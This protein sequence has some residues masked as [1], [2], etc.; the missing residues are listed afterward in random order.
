M[1][2]HAQRKD[3]RETFIAL[4]NKL[5]TLEEAKTENKTNI[6]SH[7]KRVDRLEIDSREFVK[8]IE[9]MSV[10]IDFLFKQEKKR[11]GER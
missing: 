2:E 3:C 4:F 7:E 6:K 11:N 5:G 8:M 1:V 9:K 10:Q